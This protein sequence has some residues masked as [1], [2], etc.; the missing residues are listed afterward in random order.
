MMTLD[1]SADTRDVVAVA[2]STIEAVSAAPVLITE[3]EVA[4]ATAAA[5]PVPSPTTRRWTKAIHAAC[6]VFLAAV[7]DS[8]PAR[9]NY[10]RRYLYVENPRMAR[11][12]DRL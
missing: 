5:V 7:G 12:M 4:F 3:R 8:H 1:K 10:P 9:R 2:E 6:G 11:E